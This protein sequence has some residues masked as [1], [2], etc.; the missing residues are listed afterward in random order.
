[1][2]GKDYLYVGAIVALLL[3]NAYSWFKPNDGGNKPPVDDFT[4]PG[5]VTKP[6]TSVKCPETIKAIDPKKLKED[7]AKEQSKVRELLE[8]LKI[9]SAEKEKTVTIEKVKYPDWFDPNKTAILAD[10]YIPAWKGQTYVVS[11]LDLTTGAGGITY[12]QLPR[13]FFAFENEARIGAGYI[14]VGDDAGKIMLS[15]QYTP[16][17]MGNWYLTGFGQ[18]VGSRTN[19]GASVEYRW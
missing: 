16:F 18:I 7:F 6:T 4:V 13:P 8:K 11:T 19:A 3:L 14:L 5:T 1:M 15:G 17:R 10:K 9:L 12:K 2:N